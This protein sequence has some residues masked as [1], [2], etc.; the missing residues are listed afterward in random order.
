MV[1]RDQWSCGIFVRRRVFLTHRTKNDESRSMVMRHFCKK[2]SF[3]N[4][5][6]SASLCRV[7]VLALVLEVEVM[8]LSQGRWRAR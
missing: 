6:W 5:P 8:M 7:R 1:N 2:E 4:T 3:S